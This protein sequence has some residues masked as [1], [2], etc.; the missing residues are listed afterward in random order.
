MKQTD[1]NMLFDTNEKKL[2][3]VRKRNNIVM[4]KEPF[5]P[6]G[7]AHESRQQ[8]LV[9]GIRKCKDAIKIVGQFYDSNWYDSIEALLDAIDW[10]WMEAAQ[11]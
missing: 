10:D 5:Y 1:N 3:F 6:W 7:T 9:A 8:V 11:R 2:K 4:F